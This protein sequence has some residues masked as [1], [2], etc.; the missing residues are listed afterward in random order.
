MGRG[1]RE[2]AGYIGMYFN[3]PFTLRTSHGKARVEFKLD[4]NSWIFQSRVV[5]HVREIT[6]RHQCGSMMLRGF[7]STSSHFLNTYLHGR[8]R[9]QLERH[10]R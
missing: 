6:T 10:N 2:E 9:Y 7:H 5:L 3:A 1:C 4:F 8:L